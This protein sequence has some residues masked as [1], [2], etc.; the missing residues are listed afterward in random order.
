M[1]LLLT[2]FACVVMFGSI[3]FVGTLVVISL[4]NGGIEFPGEPEIADA[5]AAVRIATAA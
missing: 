3:A 5:L 2:A 1:P 4:I